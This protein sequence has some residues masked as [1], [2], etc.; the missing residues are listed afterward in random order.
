ML[1]FFRQIYLLSWTVLMKLYC[2]EDQ[3]NM[4]VFT[5]SGSSESCAGHQNVSIGAPLVQQC[6]KALNDISLWHAVHGY[7]DMLGY[8]EMKLPT[9]SQETVLFESLLDLSQLWES[10]GRK[11]SRWFVN[12][13]WARWRGL[14][15]SETGLRINFRTLSGCQD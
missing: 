7:L 5:L 1:Q 15:Y 13:H 3:R 8:K 14:E 2:M 11:I 4:R 10:L 6:Q 9:R 12:Q